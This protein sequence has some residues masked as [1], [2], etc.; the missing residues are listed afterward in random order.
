M[1]K[2][3]K[4]TITVIGAGLAGSEAAFQLAKRGFPVELVEMRPIKTTPAH[5]T[6]SF[7]EL[8]C[9]NSLRSDDA[10]YNAVGLLH[11]ELRQMGSLIM[12]MADKH[13]VPA[14]GALAVDREAFSKDIT[15]TLGENPLITVIHEERDLSDIKT[16]TLVATGPLTSDKM[17]KSL[18]DITQTEHLHFF[19]AIAPIVYTESIDMQNAWYQSRYDKGD[20]YDY[21]N[22][23]LEKDEYE[24]FVNALNEGEK[25]TFKEFEKNTPYFEG[26]L[27]VEVLAS[28][29]KDTLAFGP[30][31]PVGLRNP[32]R[33]NKRPYA[34]LQL[35]KETKSGTL[36]N[37]VG[38]QTKL[39]YGAQKEIFKMIPALKNVTFARFG[40]IHRNT[41][42][43]SPLVLDDRL[44]LKK[45]PLIKVAGQVG[46]CEGYIESAAM[47]FLA[48]LFLADENTPLP[49]PETALGSMLL[50][51]T[52]G[53]E[54]TF[55][56]MNINFGIFPTLENPLNPETGKKAKGR[57]RKALYARRALEKLAQWKERL[58]S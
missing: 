26:C 25:V 12:Q 6:D 15:K 8:V 20:K 39:T 2:S 49:P 40:G 16:P 1:N 42:L 5:K 56:P 24:A 58:N 34:V 57:D 13:K 45:N 10:L 50:H 47:G 30:M 7:A 11:E 27:P 17:A 54:E 37:M 55:Q 38:F 48:G 32:H 21:L 35:R 4:K 43:H 3:D 18:Q 19:D 44:S 28:R 53:N 41:F 33:D 36:M 22:C 51:V 29:G 31:K 23:P 14:G 46:G 52:H 9:S